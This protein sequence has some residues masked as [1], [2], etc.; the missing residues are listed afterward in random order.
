MKRIALFRHHPECSNQ[1]CD[2]MMTALNSNYH[3]DIFSEE[4]ASPALF[5]EYDIL[6]F[7]GGIGDVDSYDKFFRRKVA[8]AVAYH[9]ERGGYYLG[10]CMGA[11]WAG[12]H[13]FDILNDI[14][15]VQYIKRPKADVRRPYGTIANVEWLGRHE[16]MFFY[17]GCALIGD[18]NKCKVIARY[19]N[20]DPMAIIQG[21]V[22]LIGCHPESEKFWFD[23]YKYIKDFWHEHRHHK[24]LLEFVD[25]LTTQGLIHNEIPNFI[26]DAGWSAGI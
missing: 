20:G 6:A 5:S 19:D 4:Q 10:I 22:G 14:E 11:Y 12:S 8:N 15:P 17:D 3:I 7:P 16:S 23:Q 26:L 13:Y 25:E 24:M 18:E 21:R 2:G 9:V 1:C